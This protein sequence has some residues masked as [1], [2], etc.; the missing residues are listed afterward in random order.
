MRGC[1][2]TYTL[3]RNQLYAVSITMPLFVVCRAESRCELML[4]VRSI[5]RILVGGALPLYHGYML[6]TCRM[7]FTRL[8][9][10]CLVTDDLRTSLERQAASDGLG[11]DGR[12]RGGASEDLPRF[13]AG[14]LPLASS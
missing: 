10:T 14:R 12:H 2:N 4:L 1:I 9:H 8:T 13:R 7:T 3:V 6:Y 11:L 5:K